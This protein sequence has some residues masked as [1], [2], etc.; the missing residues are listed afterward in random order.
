MI[1]VNPVSCSAEPTKDLAKLKILI[2]IKGLDR[3]V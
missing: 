2:R 1:A 3:I